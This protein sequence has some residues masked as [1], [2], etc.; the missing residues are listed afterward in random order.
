MKFGKHLIQQAESDWSVY[1]IEY[2]ELKKLI[3]QIAQE[4]AGADG[5][6]CMDAISGNCAQTTVRCGVT[7]GVMQVG[8][9]VSTSRRSA[10][11][12]AMQLEG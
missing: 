9:L 10:F 1:Y 8:L 6:A 2:Q 4:K 11:C 7:G 12:K 3:K 5:D